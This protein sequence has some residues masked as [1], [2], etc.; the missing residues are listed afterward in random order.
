MRRDLF[1]LSHGGPIA[2]P[3]DA[4]YIQA[5]TD[6]VWFVGASSLERMAVE[7]PLT[8]LTRRFKAIPLRAAGPA[9]AAAGRPRPARK[10]A[11]PAGA[12]PPPVPPTP[13]PS[14][15]VPGKTHRVSQIQK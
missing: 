3:E 12:A 15:H 4:A 7:Q 10:A 2:T 5:H 13:M 1:F 8:D 6:A 14:T 9:R 11:R